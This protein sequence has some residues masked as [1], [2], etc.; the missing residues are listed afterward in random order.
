MLETFENNEIKEIVA[1]NYH[2]VLAYKD[3]YEVARLFVL[4][5]IKKE[6]YDLPQS[7]G[8]ATWH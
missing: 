7:S 8:R 2:K 5:E 6:L 1:V 4:P 3:E